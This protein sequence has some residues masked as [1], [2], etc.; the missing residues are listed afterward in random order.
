MFQNKNYCLQ[1][2]RK[3]LKFK[4]WKNWSHANWR[5]IF[6]MND[7]DNFYPKDKILNKSLELVVSNIN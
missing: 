3:G 1:I 4:F 7:S 6:V 5:R 2:F